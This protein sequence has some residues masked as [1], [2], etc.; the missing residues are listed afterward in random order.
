MTSPV[1]PGLVPTRPS[2]TWLLTAE[3]LLSWMNAVSVEAMSPGSAAIRVP[4]S[5]GVPAAWLGASAEAEG[6]A[7]ELPGAV[8]GAVVG[9][10]VAVVPP[11]AVTRMVAA[12]IN[13]PNR[14]RDMR[15]PPPTGWGDQKVA[16]RAA[17]HRA[18]A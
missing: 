15:G 12:A 17:R 6:A 18:S 4:P 2:M 8:V 5:L 7:A 16:R 1:V 13:A 14:V 11:H 3:L 10:D 9:A